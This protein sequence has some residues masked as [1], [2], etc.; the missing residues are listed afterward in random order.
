MLCVDS[1][2]VRS[3]TFSGFFV[4][5]HP[6]NWSPQLHCSHLR[7]LFVVVDTRVLAQRALATWRLLFLR[8]LW[9][10]SHIRQSRKSNELIKGKLSMISL[11][12]ACLPSLLHWSVPC[13]CLLPPC[14]KMINGGTAMRSI[15]WGRLEAERWSVLLY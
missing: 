1:P 10:N 5:S 8:V 7:S 3:M 4:A 9:Q 15:S 2:P 13:S 11:C 12:L 6:S 14:A